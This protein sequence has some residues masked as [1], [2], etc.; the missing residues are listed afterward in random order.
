MIPQPPPGALISAHRLIPALFR[1]GKTLI[2]GWPDWLHR[3]DHL[4]D[5]QA[6]II[7]R[8][9]LIRAGDARFHQN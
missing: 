9:Y 4:V 6:G 1:G 7:C 2:V 3:P 5:L 8:D